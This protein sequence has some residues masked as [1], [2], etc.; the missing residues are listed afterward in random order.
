AGSC[1]ATGETGTAERATSS[2][3]ASLI[4][5]ILIGAGHLPFR[6]LALRVLALVVKLLAADEGEVRLRDASSKVQIER[7]EGEP[8]L[9]DLADQPSDLALVEEKLAR[10]ERIVVEA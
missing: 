10:A 2:S 1:A 3:S 6:I 8:L 7:D 5:D 4:S 9:L